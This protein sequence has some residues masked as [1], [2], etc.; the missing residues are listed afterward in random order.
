MFHQVNKSLLNR[1]TTEVVQYIIYVCSLTF[2]NQ[3]VENFCP[4]LKTEMAFETKVIG[5][6]KHLA[7]TCDLFLCPK[8]DCNVQQS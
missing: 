1:G 7:L 3:E 6:A 8:C 4:D 5:D 2:D